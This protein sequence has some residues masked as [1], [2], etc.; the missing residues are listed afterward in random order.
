MR[1][2]DATRNE[3][4][5][6]PVATPGISPP[7]VIEGFR[8]H[9]LDRARFK[10]AS[11]ARMALA[12]SRDPEVGASLDEVTEQ[13]LM[14]YAWWYF[15]PDNEEHA[16]RR[17]RAL[18]NIKN[19]VFD[20]TSFMLSRFYWTDWSHIRPPISVL[21]PNGQEW[22]VDAVSSNGEGWKVEGEVPNITASPSI[23]V[24][25]YHGYL[26]GGVFTPNL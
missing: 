7:E 21:C 26:C 1:K 14:W 20:R 25:G 22:C 11:D 18:E 4:R 9:F 10:I 8:C 19:G 24:P 5:P 17:T 13:C 2:G 12:H 3:A 23:L 6:V 15:D 16:P